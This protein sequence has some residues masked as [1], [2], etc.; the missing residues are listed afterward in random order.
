MI[1]KGGRAVRRL[2]RIV[3]D[4]PLAWM[5]AGIGAV[6]VGFAGVYWLLGHVGL[7]LLEFTYETD[8]L[9]SFGDALY[10]SLVT[11]SSLGYGDIRPLGWSRLFV[12]AEVMLGLAFFG[13]LVAKISSVKQDYILRRLY[14]A[15]VVDN[16]LARFVELLEEE[17]KLYRIT[18]NLLLDGEID[19]ELTT[20]FKAD[21]E[22]STFF[23]QTHQL[24]HE[25]SDLMRFEI[26]NG[27]FFGEVSDSLLS[28]MY[29]SIEGMV[30][31][32]LRIVERDP[33]AACRYVLCGNERWIAELLDLGDEISRL[34]ARHSRNEEIVAQC[35]ELQELNA[36]VRR[37]VMPLLAS[38]DA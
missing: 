7:G 33:D 19:P 4:V 15:D 2:L 17:G 31:H 28:Q 12:G 20:T 9:I 38:H 24:V 34:G 27:G 30:R 35:E 6:I 29:A 11:V 21:V 8:R 10:F 14:Y 3:N 18:S 25:L 32:T 1:A 13:L 23:Y 16:K 37:D 22:E 26:H 5:F 36:G